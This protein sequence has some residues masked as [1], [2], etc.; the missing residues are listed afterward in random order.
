MPSVELSEDRR[1]RKATQV[2]AFFF[3]GATSGT[4]KSAWVDSK[5]SETT[6]D[7]FSF[8]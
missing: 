2:I 4:Y 1:A 3:Q 6:W 5:W 8:E 7:N